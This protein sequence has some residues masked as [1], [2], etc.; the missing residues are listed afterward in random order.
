MSNEMNDSNKRFDLL[1][2]TMQDGFDKLAKRMDRIENNER[3][4]DFFK[5]EVIEKLENSIRS[6]KQSNSNVENDVFAL[7][8]KLNQVNASKGSSRIRY[9]Y[10]GQ[11]E[12]N[13]ISNPDISEY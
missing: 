3:K 7:T 2:K 5:Q 6:L 11:S 10:N 4:M 9:F 13:S 12:A 8:S 1:T